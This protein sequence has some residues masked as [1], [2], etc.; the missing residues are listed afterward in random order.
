VEINSQTATSLVTRSHELSW[1]GL[2]Q[3]CPTF[4]GKGAQTLLWVGS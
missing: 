1:E 4:Y 2:M 3:G